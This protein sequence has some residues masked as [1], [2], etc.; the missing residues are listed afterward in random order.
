MIILKTV[1]DLQQ[2]KYGDYL[3]GT[4]M[5]GE[6][7]KVSKGLFHGDRVST[8][9]NYVE[10]QMDDGFGGHRGNHLNIELGEIVILEPGDEE[11]NEEFIKRNLTD[12]TQPL[13]GS[14]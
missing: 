10:V 14:I 5:Y 4:E 3:K 1:A 2:I 12:I 13:T 9:F 7:K 6:T 8:Y 11:Y